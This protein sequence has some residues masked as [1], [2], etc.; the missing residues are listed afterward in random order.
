MQQKERT[1]PSLPVRYEYICKSALQIVFIKEFVRI[2]CYRNVYSLGNFFLF[3]NPH[4]STY[5]QWLNRWFTCSV[6]DYDKMDVL[7]ISLFVRF[8]LDI[9]WFK[10][11]KKY[12]GYDS[13][14]TL[15]A[16]DETYN[17]GPIDNSALFKGLVLL[18]G[19]CLASTPF[20]A[21]LCLTVIAVFLRGGE[22]GL[23]YVYK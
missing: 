16:G 4:V 2:I 12:V 3:W 7:Y 5:K 1:Q 17:P 10:Q 9:R 22:G 21:G 6:V 15:N 8:L 13:W 18:L 11:W 20:S 23:W 14:D 19:L